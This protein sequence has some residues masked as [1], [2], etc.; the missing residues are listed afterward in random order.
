MGEESFEEVDFP[1]EEAENL[2]PLVRYSA[3]VERLGDLNS[4]STHFKRLPP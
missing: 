1:Y 3:K 4:S 2:I